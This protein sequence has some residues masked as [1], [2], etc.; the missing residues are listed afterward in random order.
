[1]GCEAF[2]P[3]CGAISAVLV[4][5]GSFGGRIQPVIRAR[6]WPRSGENQNQF[7][8]SMGLILPDA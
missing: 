2:R 1:M 4:P 6:A 3:D 8:W 5:L 7:L